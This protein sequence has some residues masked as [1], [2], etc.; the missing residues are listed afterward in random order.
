MSDYSKVYWENRFIQ[1]KEEQNSIEAME[2]EYNLKSWFCHFTL[3]LLTQMFLGYSDEI[4]VIKQLT[5]LDL[6]GYIAN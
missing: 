4:T 1:N 6:I 3:Q 5:A 2:K